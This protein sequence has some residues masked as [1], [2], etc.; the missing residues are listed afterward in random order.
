MPTRKLRCPGPPA[1]PTCGAYLGEVV[2]GKV[3]V[4]CSRCKTHHTLLVDDLIQETLDW[5]NSVQPVIR[6]QFLERLAE[7]QGRNGRDGG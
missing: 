2:G 7:E 6:N 1:G 4:Y 5:L 3:R